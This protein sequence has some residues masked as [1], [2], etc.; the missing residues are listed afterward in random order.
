MSV[1]VIAVKELI[2]MRRYVDSGA[3]RSY[4]FRKHQLEALRD[5]ILKYEKDIYEALFKDLKKSP[6]EAYATEIGL[7]L[8][9]IRLA[10]KNLSKWTEPTHVRTNLLN[11]PSSSRIIRDPL[12]VVMIIGPWNY[13]FQLM[14]MP[15]VGAI[16]GG[17]AVLLKPSELAPA[18]A[19]VLERII[20]DI[21]SK[22]YIS[23]VLG[24]GKE[25]IQP[26]LDLFRFDH[27][28]YTGGTAVGTI[29][30][31]LAAQKLV[32]VTLE[33]GGKNPAVVEKDADL[34]V[35]ARRIALGK[36][37]NAGQT[38]VAPDYL[39]VHESVRERFLEKLYESITEFFGVDP[40]QS[41]SYGRIVNGKRFDVLIQMM[42]GGMKVFG[43]RY[44]RKSLYIAPTVLLDIDP[45]SP[46]MTEEIFGPVLPVF[47]FEAMEEAL[48]LI[49]SNPAPLAFYLFTRD[50]TKEDRWL[51]RVKFGGG[52]VNNTLWHLSNPQLPF[53]GVGTS[54]I[55]AYHGKHSIERFTHGK[56]VMKS[57][58]WFD[59]AIK[60][61]PFEGKLKWYK[62]MIR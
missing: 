40:S 49:G 6:E 1:P 36:F 3:T 30:Y 22:R 32:P 24:E 48:E 42:V 37:L 2:E 35:A 10:L 39:L 45:D 52:C 9:E 50:A 57:P 17:N 51:S 58:G 44:D 4:E 55:G 29:I 7:V 61:P 15:L 13:P 16:A 62:R 8:T 5:A 47:S 21:F 33:L 60:Y 23:I 41:S 28:F 53:G 19:Y 38:C 12:G 20:R 34:K 59:P 18:S 27:V 56:P 31:Q 43:G 54:G 46:I 26:L 25:T 11:F 14:L